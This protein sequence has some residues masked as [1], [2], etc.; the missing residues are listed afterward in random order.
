M[1]KEGA[2]SKIGEG[3]IDNQ[4][5]KGAKMTIVPR[6]SQDRSFFGYASDDLLRCAK[7]VRRLSHGVRS[8]RGS[9]SLRGVRGWK[10]QQEQKR[11][12]LYD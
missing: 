7:T 1:K 6:P 10:N 12:T 9:R 3:A 11:L 8:A 2:L 4:W 5:F